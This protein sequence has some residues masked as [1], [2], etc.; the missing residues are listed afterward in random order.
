M[1]RL[2][3]LAL[4]GMSI[5]L[6]S[7]CSK[8]QV[9]ATANA[10]EAKTQTEKIPEP[11]PP[12]ALSGKSGAVVETMDA[13]GYTYVQVDTGQEKLWAAAPQFSV[14]V[15][16]QVVIPEGMA[17][18]NYH[19]KTL[20]RDFDVVYFV[21]SV[22]NASN[23]SMPAEMTNTPNMQIPEGHPP[24]TGMTPPPTID[25]SGLTKVEGGY[26]VGDIYAEKSKLS[27]QTI[28]VRG[29]VV[30][31]SPQIMGTNWIHIQDGTGEQAAAT[32]D[33]TITSDT[34]VKIGDTIVIEGPLTLDKDFGYGYQYDLII[35]GAQVTPE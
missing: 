31:F 24:L 11:T 28:K 26:T 7:A 15:G 10:S 19:S 9:P 2:F 1:N 21:E 33:L 13:S 29:K 32:H 14:A 27:G 8:E 6:F 17:M 22:L 23:P 30:K 4:A 34:Q 18:K 25:F 35:E 16:D 20:D 5:L 3:I 12:P